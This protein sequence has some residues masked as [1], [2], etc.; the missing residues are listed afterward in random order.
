MEILIIGLILVA[1]MVYTSTKIKAAV[2]AAYSE[3]KIQTPDFEIIKPDGFLSPCD[4]KSI[5][6]FEAYSRD[7]GEG[8]AA[9][10]H[11]VAVTLLI[12]ERL[13][14][15]E[16]EIESH[17]VKNGVSL[18]IIRKYLHTSRNTYELTITALK[19]NYQQYEERIQKMLDSFQIRS[20]S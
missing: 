9:D 15:N 8:K 3:E 2:A 5:Y 17:E 14:F 7:F 11:H 19:D 6:A 4:D 12:H 1:L 18:K 16:A 13:S 20:T 10:L